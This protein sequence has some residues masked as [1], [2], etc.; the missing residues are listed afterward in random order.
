MVFVF[1]LKSD[2]YL[3]SISD[4]DSL[5]PQVAFIKRANHPSHKPQRAAPHLGFSPHINQKYL[6]KGE[7]NKNHRCNRT[8]FCFSSS[9]LISSGKERQ[10]E[11]EMLVICSCMDY[12]HRHCVTS[13][14]SYSQH[15]I[16]TC[17]V[18]QSTLPSL[19]SPAPAAL[20]FDVRT[21]RSIASTSTLPTRWRAT[22]RKP[23]RAAFI[24]DTS[25]TVTVTDFQ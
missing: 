14:S 11:T 15:H 4:W 13:S 16:P 25:R 9:A 12:R 21:G 8:Y 5:N 19:S 18:M 10:G 3:T 17:S 2:Q 1:W 23:A 22:R 7:R 6:I 24:R 20:C